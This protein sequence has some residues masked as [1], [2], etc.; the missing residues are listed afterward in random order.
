MNKILF[1]FLLGMLTLGTLTACVGQSDA[2]KSDG[3][4]DPAEIPKETPVATETMK[5]AENRKLKM[6]VDGQE[7]SITL[8]D[9]PTANALYEALPM[10]LD[11]SD[12]NGTEKIAYP[13]KALPTKGEP[14]GFDPKVGDLCLYAPWGNLCIFYRDFRYSEALIWLGHVESGLDILT[15]KSGN[16]KATLDKE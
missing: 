7:I 10:E 13:P 6:T 5:P 11:F 8:Y 9:T 14:D 16:F 15:G 3:Y 2:G 1:L 4:P 12:F